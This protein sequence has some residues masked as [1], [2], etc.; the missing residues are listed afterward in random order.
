M[1]THKILI[2]SKEIPDEQIKKLTTAKFEKRPATDIEKKTYIKSSLKNLLISLVCTAFGILTFAGGWLIFGAIGLIGGLIFII[3]AITEFAKLFKDIRKTKPED[4][5]RALLEVVLIGDDSNNFDKKS[6][7]YAYNSL[8]RMVPD[9]VP[10]TEADF[11]RYI[12]EFRAYIKEKVTGGY[13]DTFLEDF[14]KNG[15]ANAV[16]LRQAPGKATVKTENAYMYN[17][18]YSIEYS[19]VSKEEARKRGTA[20]KAAPYARFVVTFEVLLINS[21]KYWFLADPLPEIAY[22]SGGV[23]PVGNAVTA[24]AD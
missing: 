9:F 16:I 22:P 7:K 6:E 24:T 23:A 1:R 13:D 5:V 12:G 4:A 2:K 20:A 3:T 14:P 19:A 17:V 21:D 18:D 10:F 15:T 8:C 11:T